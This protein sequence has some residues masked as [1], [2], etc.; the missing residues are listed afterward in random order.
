MLPLKVGIEITL[1]NLARRPFFT[2]VLCIEIVGDIH[3]WPFRRVIVIAEYY[4][5][6]VHEYRHPAVMIAPNDRP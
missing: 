3:L 4:V 5:A 6:N 1:E 2:I